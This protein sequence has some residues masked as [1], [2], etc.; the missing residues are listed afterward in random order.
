[1]QKKLFIDV[2]Y[3]NG[4]SIDFISPTRSVGGRALTVNGIKVY[5]ANP[6]TVGA[7]GK[8]TGASFSTFFNYG[9]VRA[10]GLDVG[11]T[12]T[13]SKFVNLAVKYSWFNSDITKDDIK[14]DANSDKYVSLEE[15]SLNAPKNRGIAILDFQNLCKDKLFINLSARFVEQYDFYSVNQIGTKAG[16]GRRGSVAWI[17]TNGQTRYYFK[18]FDHG[19]LG[20]FI[21][22]DLSATYKVNEMVSVNMGITNLFNTR[23]IEFVGSPSIGRLIMFELKVHVPK[24][25]N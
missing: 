13:F 7:D 11:L 25:K 22:I 21:T 18:N 10:Y 4:L 17:D 15:T 16:K 12:Y 9:Q 5:P 3:Y 2:N 23:Q 24:N 19:P 1:M 14:N 8:L 20:G 6:G